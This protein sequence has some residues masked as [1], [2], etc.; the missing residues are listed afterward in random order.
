MSED[1]PHCTANVPE[2]STFGGITAGNHHQAEPIALNLTDEA[3][4]LVAIGIRL[5]A[6]LRR[7]ESLD[8]RH[9]KAKMAGKVSSES[10]LEDARKHAY[11]EIC[12]QRS[13]LSFLKAT[14]LTGAALQI[15]EALNVSDLIWNNIPESS[16]FPR[17]DEYQR[18]IERLLFSALGIVESVASQRVEDIVTRG[19][20]CCNTNPWLAPEDRCEEMMTEAAQ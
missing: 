13:A 7:E 16:D 4:P 12:A 9:T 14:S 17:L 19:Y 3:D 2:K 6:A 8:S 1:R 5:G 20:A 11:D 10:Y 15:V 18:E